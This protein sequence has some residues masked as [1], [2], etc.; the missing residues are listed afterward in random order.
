ML[1]A[2]ALLIG[3]SSADAQEKSVAS[4]F[5]EAGAAAAQRKDFAV[6]AESFAE[7]HRL[8][9]HSAAIYNAALCWES[10]G[11]LGLAARGYEEALK[12]RQLHPDQEQ[13]ASRRLTGLLPKLA[14]LL[15]DGPVGTTISTR[16]AKNI[17]TPARLL[18]EPGPLV[19]T[20]RGPNGE[21]KTLTIEA[22]TGQLQE[23]SVHFAELAPSKK[24]KP[25]PREM[26]PTASP[27]KTLG[28]I[29]IG[30]GA[31]TLLTAGGFYLAAVSARNDFE[32]S[33][34]R[35]G[36]ARETAVDRLKLSRI[37]GLGGAIVAGIGVTLV[38]TDEP[39]AAKVQVRLSPGLARGR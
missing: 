30:V 36:S 37:L 26:E 31:A 3:V 38:I 1:A 13:Q 14:R 39:D 18:T 25:P 2:V 21:Q 22:R 6:C 10:E 28:W 20:A 12:R 34:R 11:K 15:V 9:P 33:G 29:G 35:D 24:A 27:T 19:I 32:D 8:E 5:F 7:A 17:S 23:V 16:D 4:G